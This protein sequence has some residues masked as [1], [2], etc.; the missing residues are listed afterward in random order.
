MGE[1]LQ[2]PGNPGCLILS[3]SC[4]TEGIQEV[5]AAAQCTPPPPPSTSGRFRNL[6]ASISRSWGRADKRLRRTQWPYHYRLIIFPTHLIDVTHGATGN[7]LHWALFWAPH[8]SGGGK[9]N[10]SFE[11]LGQPLPQG[12]LDVWLPSRLAAVGWG[13]AFC[14]FFSFLGLQVQG[15]DSSSGSCQEGV[16][17]DRKAQGLS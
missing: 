10:V 9:G 6:L 5:G 13:Q 11:V 4:K 15:G 3:R 16:C 2:A 14:C 1:G 17:R 7:S 12:A 8:C